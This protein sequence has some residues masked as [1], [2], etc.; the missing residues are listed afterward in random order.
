LAALADLAV[1]A[2]PEVVAQPIVEEGRQVLAA[3]LVISALQDLREPQESLAKSLP[4]HRQLSIMSD[5]STPLIPSNVIQNWLAIILAIAFATGILLPSILYGLF[6]RPRLPAD[7]LISCGMS[8]FACIVYLWTLHAISVITLRDSWMSK[9]IFSAA[10][11]GIL[12]ASV[13]IYKN[14]GGNTFPLE[15]L[16]EFRLQRNVDGN[17]QCTWYGEVMIVNS[18]S[19][20]VYIGLSGDNRDNN[21]SELCPYGVKLLKSIEWN[22]RDKQFSFLIENFLPSPTHPKDRAA[23]TTPLR[24]NLKANGDDWVSEEPD[25]NSNSATF[26]VSL[27][28]Q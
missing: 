21:D 7:V 17:I 11:M 24:F 12:G 20:N 8:L 22:D 18:I 1:R 26:S 5:P 16:W 9:A 13:T 10:I 2:A 19:K 14:F 4:L 27:H 15:G 3:H 23:P 6:L 28:R 25:K